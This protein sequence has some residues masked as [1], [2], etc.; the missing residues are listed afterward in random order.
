MNQPKVYYSAC[1]YVSTSEACW[2]IFGY[3]LHNIQPAV[4]RLPVHEKDQQTIVYTD[5]DDLP[6]VLAAKE[7]T[8]LTAYF[9][10]NAKDPLAATMKYLDIPK[11]FSWKRGMFIKW[12]HTFSGE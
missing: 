1:R 5:D 8:M 3:S 7:E 11:H 12:Y 10:L 9:K 6:T 4:Y 2:R